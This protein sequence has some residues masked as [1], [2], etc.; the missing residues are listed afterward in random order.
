MC[1]YVCACVFVFV[2]L[3]VCVRV[4]VCVCEAHVRVQM[5]ECACVLVR[6][7]A[8][9]ERTCTRTRHHTASRNRSLPQHH[10][11]RPHGLPPQVLARAA[12]EGAEAL[13]GSASEGV[14]AEAMTLLA[15]AYHAQ[16]RMDEA[17]AEYGRVSG[18]GVAHA[19]LLSAAAAHATQ[20]RV[21]PSFSL[22]LGPWR[23]RF[24]LP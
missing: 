1:V 23:A 3:C 17:R 14:R 4:C 18:R 15:R 24:A 10:R 20:R 13:P 7:Y 21:S 11:A 6:V 5:W 22:S 12:L 9:P 16:G 19:A 2:C 8:C